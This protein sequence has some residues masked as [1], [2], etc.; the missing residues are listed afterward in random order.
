MTID[1]QIKAA[2]HRIA[3]SVGQKARYAK[4][5]IRFTAELMRRE[6]AS[7]YPAQHNRSEP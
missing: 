7:R 5:E 3:R 2:Q 1:E 6:I 4:A